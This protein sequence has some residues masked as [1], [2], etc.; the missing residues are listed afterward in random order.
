[1]KNSIENRIEKFIRKEE[2]SY[3]QKTPSSYNKWLETKKVIPEGV[4]YRIRKLNP[5]PIYVKKGEKIYIH[6]IDSNIYVDYWLGHGTNILGHNP[7][8]IHELIQEILEKGIHTG[9]PSDVLHDY[10]R[11]IL[12]AYPMMD[13]VKLFNSGTDS[14]IAAIRVARAYTNKKKII[15]IKGGWHGGSEYLFKHV[16][17]PYT[18]V[19]VAGI[20]LECAKNTKTVEYNDLEDLEKELKN[21]DIAAVIIEPVLGAGGAI[22]PEKN[23][24]Q[25]VRYLTTKYDALLIFDEVITGFRLSFGGAVEYFGV[26]PDLVV[27]GKIVGG[28]SPSAGALVGKN[29]FMECFEPQINKWKNRPCFSGGTFTGNNMTLLLGKRMLEELEKRKD[30]YRGLSQKWKKIAEKISNTCNDKY[31]CHV[32]GEGLIIGIH[33]TTK[34]P[35]NPT[36]AHLFRYSNKLYYLY[37]LYMRNRGVLYLTEDNIHLLPSL[38]HGEKEMLQFLELHTRFIEMLGKA[39]NI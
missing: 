38:L 1:M 8:F 10:A 35:K 24:L 6:D 20:D 30:L 32:T 16:H 11:K 39:I 22:G 12:T 4:N 2:E 18:D 15:K 36:E 9:H 37:N 5:H 34:R 19:E 13:K 29:E 28:G 21:R 25:E 26:E 7:P 27:L 17:P 23:Y 14:V 31:P 33:F 3:I